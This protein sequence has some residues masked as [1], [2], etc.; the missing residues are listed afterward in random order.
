MDNTA[1]HQELQIVG[2]AAPQRGKELHIAVPALRGG[3]YIE[4]SA[5]SGMRGDFHYRY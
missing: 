3:G 2:P 5:R 4:A 1:L